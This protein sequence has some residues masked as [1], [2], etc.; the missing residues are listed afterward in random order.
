M[1]LAKLKTKISIEEYLNGEEVSETRHEYIKGEF[2]AM[3]DASQNH[4]RII[5][6][7]LTSLSNHLGNSPCKPFSG[8]IKVRTAEEFFLLSRCSGNLRRQLFKSFLCRTT[9]FDH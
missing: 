6:N 9:C 2:Y 8:N 1:G 5:R 4:N 3:A 7:F